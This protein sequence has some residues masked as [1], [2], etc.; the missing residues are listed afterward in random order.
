LEAGRPDFRHIAECICEKSLSPILAILAELGMA[1][2]IYQQLSQERHEIRLLVIEPA[3]ENT[4]SLRAELRQVSLDDNPEYD[5]LSYVWGNKEKPSRLEIS[6]EGSRKEFAITRN[7]QLALGRL[8]PRDRSLTI[9]VDAVCINQNDTAECNSQVSMMGSIYRGA[10]KVLAFF[11]EGASDENGAAGAIDFIQRVADQPGH[12]FV[13]T[14]EPSVGSSFRAEF[15]KILHFFK[16]AW[17]ERVWTVQEAVLAANLIIIY[18]S[19]ELEIS[20]L[21]QFCNAL[22]FH[23]RYCCRKFDA[24]DWIDK[25]AFSTILQF[26]SIAQDLGLYRF[27]RHAS[28]DILD[29][30]SKFRYRKSSDLRDKI[31]GFGALSTLPAGFVDYGLPVNEV[32][33][34]FTIMT[35]ED[36]KNLDIFNHFITSNDGMLN[37]RIEARKPERLKDLP[38]WV[39]DWSLELKR[40]ASDLLIERHQFVKAFKASGETEPDMEYLAPGKLRLRGIVFDK[41][42]KV[43]DPNLE[44]R[45][46]MMALLWNWEKVAGIRES[47]SPETAHIKYSSLYQA[48][49]RAITWDLSPSDSAE[50]LLEEADAHSGEPGDGSIPRR[51]DDCRDRLLYEFWRYGSEGSDP[52]ISEGDYDKNKAVIESIREGELGHYSWKVSA[53]T[54]GKRFIVT[55]SGLLGFGPAETEVGDPICCFYGGRTPYILRCSPLPIPRILGDAYIEGFMDGLVVQLAERFQGLMPS[56]IILK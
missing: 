27:L 22:K 17:W 44:P 29:I 18:G 34:R 11:H 12:H 2:T 41:V 14:L 35:I 6:L 21:L 40:A 43:G 37:T 38:S 10:A 36:T 3:Q 49:R 42:K 51:A 15:I 39:P 13:P 48:F 55:E 54:M 53:M 5:A 24:D 4:D 9:W 56:D 45:A 30:M 33:I 46:F 47:N 25:T 52:L 31:Y 32:Y 50:S 19:R 26:V 8:R 28:G 7:L 23:R 20:D 16:R 1:D